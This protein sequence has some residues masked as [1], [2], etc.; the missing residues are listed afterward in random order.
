M[1]GCG[2]DLLHQAHRLN[3]QDNS[4]DFPAEK[5]AIHK[6][7]DGLIFVQRLISSTF[8]ASIRIITFWSRI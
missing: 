4:R 3:P 5:V 6:N 1:E 8:R 2:T 7:S